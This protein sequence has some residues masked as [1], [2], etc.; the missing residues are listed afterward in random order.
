MTLLTGRALDWASAVWDTDPQLKASTDYLLQ[1]ISEVFEYPPGDKDISTQLLHITQGN[2]TAADYAIEFRTLAA[3]SGWNDVALKSIFY[4]SLNVNLQIELA[5]CRGDFS[6]F[7]LVNMT[8]KIDNLLRQTPKNKATKVSTR[9]SI[10]SVPSTTQLQEEPM[11]L[12]V[13]RYTE[14][15]RA[16]QRQN[17]LCFYCGEPGHR[18][19]GCHHKTKSSSGVNIHHLFLLCNKSLTLHVCL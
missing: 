19:L 15:E 1:Q 5:C 3:Q 6:F 8:I 14:K 10:T 7:E 9:T 4:N 2:R 16:K 13:S 11:Q 17:R 12:T 18:S